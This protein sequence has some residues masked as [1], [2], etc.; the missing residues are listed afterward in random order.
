MGLA[1]SAGYPYAATPVVANAPLGKALK[2][3][4]LSLESDKTIF[5]FFG[6]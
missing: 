3:F 2:K 1:V 5:Y 6:F 4:F